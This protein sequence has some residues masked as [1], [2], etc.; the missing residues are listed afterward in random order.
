[1]L[2]RRNVTGD[3]G[4]SPLLR[5]FAAIRAQMDIPEDFPP[6]ASEEAR[7]A[8]HT[9]G[10]DGRAVSDLPFFTLDPPGSRDLDQ[11]MHL[12][13]DGSGYRVRY[14]IADVPTFVRPGGALDRAARDRGV[15]V[16]APDRRTPLHPVVLSEG[17]ASLLPG[18]DRPA[19]VWDVRLDGDGEISDVGLERRTVRSVARMD[20]PSVQREIDSGTPDEQ[21]VLLRDIGR[22]RADVELARGGASLALPDQEAVRQPGGWT[23]RFVP[24]LEVEDWNAQISLLTGIVAARIMVEAGVGILRTMPPAE[25]RAVRDLRDVAAG[26]GIDWPEDLSYGQMLHGIDRT[27]PRHL[28]FIH[29]A[30]RLFRGASYTVL[31]AG[32][33]S[34]PPVHAALAT[35]YAHVTAP[36]R[37]LVDRF[38][39]VVC[40]AV[41]SGRP[42][43]EWTTAG[44]PDVPKLME[45]GDRRAGSVER[46]CR[47]AVEAAVLSTRIGTRIPGVVVDEPDDDRVLVQLTSVGV[48]A[49]ASGHAERG[50]VVDVEVVDA[51]IEDG[52]VTLRIPGPD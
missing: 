24:P 7:Q 31:D 35:P 11:A 46:A 30:A 17:A 48:E 3:G 45:A 40:E 52:S 4:G 36:L 10:G 39:L 6:E 34:D 28:A 38:G 44:L 2:T 33:R 47:D 51:R 21:L 8:A 19:F 49:L 14:A 50:A 27:D 16:Y 13:R 42:V 12:A 32:S 1:M 18:Q 9:N 23:V 5:R 41:H 25:E 20:Y 37:R 26:L 29:R 15:T 43:P 22:L